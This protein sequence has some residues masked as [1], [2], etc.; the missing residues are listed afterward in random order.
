MPFSL[1][2]LA[3]EERIAIFFAVSSLYIR[4][5]KQRLMDRLLVCHNIWDFAG[6]SVGICW[7]FGFRC[8][9]WQE[10]KFAISMLGRKEIKLNHYSSTWIHVRKRKF[11]SLTSQGVCNLHEWACGL[12]GVTCYQSYQCY[13]SVWKSFFS[14]LVD[15]NSN[16]SI[17]ILSFSL[18][19]EY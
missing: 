17:G 13:L 7:D 18:D 2:A 6:V 1:V 3:R 16:V 8:V 5:H 10:K 15:E 19:G 14:F 9:G 12:Y 4:K 11:T